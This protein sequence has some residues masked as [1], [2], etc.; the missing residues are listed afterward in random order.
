MLQAEAHLKLWILGSSELWT[1]CLHTISLRLSLVSKYETFYASYLSYRPSIV[2]VIL[3]NIFSSFCAGNLKVNGI[4]FSIYRVS[5]PGSKFW[6]N[7][8]LGFS[9]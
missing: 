8:D 5:T 2:Q 4:A 3:Y 1:V 7:S 9:D 6:N